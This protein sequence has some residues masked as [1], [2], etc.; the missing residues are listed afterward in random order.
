MFFSLSHSLILI[1]LVFFFIWFD[2]KLII[3]FQVLNS[4]FFVFSI[5]MYYIIYKHNTLKVINNIFFSNTLLYIMIL[6]SLEFF[7][8][9]NNYI[10]IFNLYTINKELNLLSNIINIYF[11]KKIHLKTI[12]FWISIEK[13][14]NWILDNYLFTK[15]NLLIT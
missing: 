7:N 11:N 3:H 1:Y 6:C 10:Y 12:S 13:V 15:N 9:L 5:A 14:F 2:N 8:I 4:F